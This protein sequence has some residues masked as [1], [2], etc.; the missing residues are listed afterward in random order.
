MKYKKIKQLTD[1]PYRPGNDSWR[2]DLA[3]PADKASS[4]R[5]GLVMIHGGGWKTGDK[6]D[7]KWRDLLVE[8]AQ[9]GFVTVSMNHRLSAEA[10]YPACLDDASCAVRWLRANSET[11]NVDP[12]RIG[13][14]GESSGGQLIAMLTLTEPV[15]EPSAPYQDQSS[16]LQSAC[17]LATPTD[18][19][20]WT[21]PGEFCT[22]DAVAQLF[23]GSIETRNERARLASPLYFARADAPPLLIVH[24]TDDEIVPINQADRFV[25]TLKKAGAQDVTYLR[26][27]GVRHGIYNSLR[28]E[29]LP[30]I[31]QFFDRTIT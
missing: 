27:E 10:V 24:G 8:F 31:S 25:E 26:H 9:Q 15:V 2:L 11:Y 30:Q 29:L 5:P 19:V 23:T 6:Q 18:F 16:V 21:Q 14:I 7:S 1:I 17:L 28:D 13:G 4:P 22:R 3:M 20:N 12:A